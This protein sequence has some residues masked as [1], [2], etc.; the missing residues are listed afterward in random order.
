M[1]LQDLTTLYRFQLEML[2]I[3]RLTNVSF[4]LLRLPSKYV[5]LLNKVFTKHVGNPQTVEVFKSFILNIPY[6]TLEN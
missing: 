3:K 5:T 1:S 4:G 2:E 6:S